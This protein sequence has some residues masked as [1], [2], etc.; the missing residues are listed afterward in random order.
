[1]VGK[2][3]SEEVGVVGKS[4]LCELGLELLLLVMDGGGEVYEEGDCAC[5]FGWEWDCKGG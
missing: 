4:E 1:M 5:S 2:N 3:S